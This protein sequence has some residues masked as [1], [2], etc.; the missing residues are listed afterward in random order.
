[1]LNTYKTSHIDQKKI[2]F[3]NNINYDN[4]FNVLKQ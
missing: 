4:I 2:K 1:M 3:R